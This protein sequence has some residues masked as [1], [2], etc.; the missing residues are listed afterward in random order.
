M[1]ASARGAPRLDR[2]RQWLVLREVV[3]RSASWVLTTALARL[4]G[5]GCSSASPPRGGARASRSRSLKLGNGTDGRSVAGAGVARWPSGRSRPGSLA[6]HVRGRDGLGPPPRRGP[7]RRGRLLGAVRLPLADGG[8]QGGGPAPSRPDRG[9]AR[10]D[11]HAG[12]PPARGPTGPLARGAAR[13][14]PA[15]GHLRA[16][17]PR[18]ARCCWSATPVGGGAP[19]TA[20]ARTGGGRPRSTWTPAPIGRAWPPP[21]VGRP[22]GPVACGRGPGAR[23]SRTP[24]TAP[25]WTPRCGTTRCACTRASG[26]PAPARARTRPRGAWTAGCCTSGS[27]ST[28]SWPGPPA[29]TSIPP[30]RGRTTTSSTP[31]SPPSSPTSSASASSPPASGPSGPGACTPRSGCSRRAGSSSV[32][33]RREGRRSTSWSTSASSRPAT[34]HRLLHPLLRHG[35][36]LGLPGP[37]LPVRSSG[38]RPRRGVVGQVPRLLRRVD[39]RAVRLPRRRARVLP[40]DRGGLP[41][42]AVPRAVDAGARLRARGPDARRVRRHREGRLGPGVRRDLRHLPAAHPPPARPGPLR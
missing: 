32:A 3:P 33:T 22:S 9:R 34:T 35:L 10:G 17:P 1:E 14:H 37:G 38:P 25:R 19:S 8:G 24:S 18:A 31:R 2:D 23:P 21:R 11:G 26:R 42:P 40:R 27:R 15:G 39:A 5:L 28:R 12:R 6:I 16:G 30:G 20:G 4:A 29:R 7:P 36:D 41:G 13:L